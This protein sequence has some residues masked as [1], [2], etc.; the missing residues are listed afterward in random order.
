MTADFLT[1]F[2]RSNFLESPNYDETIAYFAQFE[3]T[4][5][6][7]MFS[8]GISPQGRPLK[9]V[10]VSS[11]GEFSPQDARAHGKIVVLIQNGVHAG[12][13]EGKDA[14]MLMLREMLIENKLSHLLRNR[15]LLIIPILNV[16]GH[17]R[18]SPYNR[19]NQ[20][21]PTSM[22]WRTT[23]W[24]L[25]LNRDYMKA[26]APEMKAL[27]QL[28]KTWQP[29][30]FIDNHTTNGADYQYHIT[31]G[32]ETHANINAPSQVHT[33]KWLATV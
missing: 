9:C 24:N 25:N 8:F 31:Y 22:G 15:V 30:F 12:E 33:W 11:H 29:D 21:G 5:Q 17:E 26:D 10:V 2:E 4:H 13:I 19:P 23:S 16:D 18:T 3:R 27:L 20:N 32:I 1:R 28:Y 6:A 7:H 14:C